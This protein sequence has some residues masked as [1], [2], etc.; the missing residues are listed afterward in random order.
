MCTL[1]IC[2][3]LHSTTELPRTEIEICRTV[4]L[5]D[6][7][8]M[9]RRFAKNMNQLGS[10]FQEVGPPAASWFIILSP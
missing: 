3:I 10:S 1:N 2:W 4:S 7:I 8:M 5:Q 6:E 9:S